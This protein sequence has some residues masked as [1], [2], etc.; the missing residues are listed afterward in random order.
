LSLLEY[1]EFNKNWS[2]SYYNFLRKNRLLNEVIYNLNIINSILDWRNDK[3]SLPIIWKKLPTNPVKIPN[4]S[5][6]Y[7]ADYTDWIHH[8][9]DFDASFWEQVNAI[10]D[11]IIVRVVSGFNF[12]DLSN[13]VR[14]DNLTYEEKLR[15]LDILRWNQVWL[16][17][18]KWDVAFY[19]HLNGIFTNIEEW[20]IVRKWQPLWTVWISWVPD[21]NYTDYHLHLPIHKNP[22][23]EKMVWKY[24]IDDYMN[25][26]W[27]FKWETSDYIVNNQNNIF[28]S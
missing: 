21:K 6:E 16:K 23:N 3:Y 5:R 26:D 27:Y 8:G 28:E 22:Y 14:W 24:D 12:S 18:M 15:N 9:W 19:S 11:G 4:S 13:I 17:T 25:W 20:T 10:D 2:I 1:N 7:R